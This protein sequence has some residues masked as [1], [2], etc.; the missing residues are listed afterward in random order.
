MRAVHVTIIIGLLAIGVPHLAAQAQGVPSTQGQGVPGA[1]PLPVPSTLPAPS[2]QQ[3][4][5][6][7]DVGQWLKQQ[8]ELSH[9]QLEEGIQHQKD[10]L[11]QICQ[12]MKETHD[13]SAPLVC[14]SAS[15]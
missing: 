15:K 1:P 14:K 10:V 12:H 2:A 4:P 11:R 5:V 7:T 9:K 8:Q 6:Q 3:Q 13:S